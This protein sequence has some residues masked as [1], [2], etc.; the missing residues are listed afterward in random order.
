VAFTTGS[1]V[2]CRLVAVILREIDYRTARGVANGIATL[3][4]TTR[5]PVA[6]MPTTVPIKDGGGKI[7]LSDLP[8]SIATQAELD[9]VAAA[10]VAKAGDTMTGE[11]VAPSLRANT[12]VQFGASTRLA[13]S[14][15]AVVSV[16]GV[17]NDEIGYFRFGNS[18]S[19]FGW[20]GTKLV[21][22]SSEVWHAGSFVPA[23]KLNTANPTGTGKL[24]I[25]SIESKGDVTA[26][27]NAADT[28]GYLWLNKAATRGLGYDGTKYVFATTAEVHGGNFIATSDRRAKKYLRK[29]HVPRG[30]ADGLK[31]YSYKFRDTGRDGRGPIAQQVLEYAP[32]RVVEGGRHLGLDQSGLAL[33]LIEDLIARVQQLERQIQKLTKK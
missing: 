16:R 4:S 31:M 10:R 21:F 24:T 19:N 33:D 29:D 30:F 8:D 15:A 3:D 14:A 2:E 23:D 1:V 28:T 18:A 27:R 9:A 7:L 6:Q 17:V 22:G 25:E 12:H 26:Y 11:L 32:W 13:D 5:I 20:N